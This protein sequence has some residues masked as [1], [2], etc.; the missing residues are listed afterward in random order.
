MKTKK[1]KTVDEKVEDIKDFAYKTLS[2]IR[3]EWDSMHRRQDAFLKR[4]E[5]Y[6]GKIQKNQEETSTFQNAHLSKIAEI[7]ICSEETLLNVLLAIRQNEYLQAWY[8]EQKGYSE[9][10]VAGLHPQK[11][12]E[13]Y[14]EKNNELRKQTSADAI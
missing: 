10:K 7:S 8:P 11:L 5:V 9:M 13:L 1:E 12:E 6:L 4:M 14:K 3:K 2:S